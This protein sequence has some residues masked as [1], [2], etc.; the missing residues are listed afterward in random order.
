[1]EDKEKCCCCCG[2]E[3]Q[4]KEKLSVVEDAEIRDDDMDFEEELCCEL[5]SQKIPEKSNTVKKT[6][7]TCC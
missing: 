2:G 5:F 4:E 1:M 6:R 3:V 7:K